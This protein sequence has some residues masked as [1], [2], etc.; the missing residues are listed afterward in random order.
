MTS[1]IAASCLRYILEC[2]HLFARFV[3]EY[4][5]II[6]I[7]RTHGYTMFF[8]KSTFSIHNIKSRFS[9]STPSLKSGTQREMIRVALLHLL[10]LIKMW[11]VLCCTVFLLSWNIFYHFLSTDTMS[12][13]RQCLFRRL[14][15]DF[16]S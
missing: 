12:M 15:G 5:R 2:V 7:L 14:V 3:L 8:L 1:I 16:L 9:T 10:Q 4:Q 11:R 13:W 6:A